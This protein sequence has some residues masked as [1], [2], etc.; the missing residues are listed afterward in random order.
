[1]RARWCSRR[2]A[3]PALL[4]ASKS[5]DVTGGGG[6]KPVAR[7]PAAGKGGIHDNAH[8]SGLAEPP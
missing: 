8:D 3:I 7:K 5:V 4:D 1:M 2:F 6:R